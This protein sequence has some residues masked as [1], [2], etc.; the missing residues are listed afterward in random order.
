MGGYVAPEW[1]R[2]QALDKLVPQR[3]LSVTSR[4]LELTDCSRHLW[5]KA[6]MESARGVRHKP[7]KSRQQHHPNV[8]DMDML[9][10]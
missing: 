4:R 6:Q 2:A 9:S 7:T 8:T 5:V 10:G 1:I 3:L